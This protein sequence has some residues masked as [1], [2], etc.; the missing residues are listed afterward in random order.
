MPPPSHHQAIWTPPSDTTS[1]AFRGFATGASRFLCISLIAHLLLSRIHPVYRNL[2]PQFKTFIQI[3]S[4]TLGGCIF[5]EKY[6]TEYNDSIRK[7]RRALERSA[8]AWSEE[9]EIRERVEREVEEEAAA[10]RKGDGG[11]EEEGQGARGKAP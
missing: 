11:G 3:S 10:R 4:G 1:V 6:V 7:R 5:A 2:T 8:R 9:R